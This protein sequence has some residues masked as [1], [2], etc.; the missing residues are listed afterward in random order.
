MAGTDIRF[1]V[2]IVLP[3]YGP[4]ASVDGVRRVAEAAEELGFDSVWVTEHLLVAR[5]RADPYGTVLEPL[6]CL[7]WLAGRL[8]RVKLGTSVILLPLHHPV[9]LAKEAATLQQLSG[10]RLKLGLG[11]GW[12]EPEFHFL[13]Y[14][15]SDRGQRADEALR[16][17][18]ALWEGQHEF[19]GDYWSFE[20]AC[21]GPLPDPAPEIWIAGNSPRSLRRAREL[22]GVWHP[23]ALNPEEVRRAKQGWPEGRIVP[24]YELKLI[25][26]KGQP[27][28]SSFGITGTPTEVADRIGELARAGADGVVLGVGLGPEAAERNLHRFAS[29]VTPRLVEQAHLERPS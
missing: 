21:F 28:E 18:R 15:F 1:E 5:E 17:M 16:L 29:E 22:G 7:A 8:E 26:H 12:H 20:D 6:S 13:G 25:E 27:S 3:N 9:D 24:R 19:H 4:H 14:G 10:G 2:G 23:L 11:V